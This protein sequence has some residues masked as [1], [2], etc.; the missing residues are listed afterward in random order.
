[1]EGKTLCY[2]AREEEHLWK[3]I[4]VVD[5]PDAPCLTEERTGYSRLFAFEAMELVVELNDGLKGVQIRGIG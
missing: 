4:R 5:Y 1:M 2:V 3:V